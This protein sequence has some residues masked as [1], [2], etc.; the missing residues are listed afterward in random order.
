MDK[1][2]RR[3]R[4]LGLLAAFPARG[5]PALRLE[6]CLVQQ[7]DATLSEL[8]TALVV[9]GGSILSQSAMGWAAIG[10]G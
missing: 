8:C 5:G 2:L 9:A 7:P 3:K 10:L 4:A 6:A 1:L